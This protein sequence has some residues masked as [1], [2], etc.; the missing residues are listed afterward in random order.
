MTKLNKVY[1]LL[2]SN[3]EPRLHYLNEAMN[4]LSQELGD[5]IDSSL[6]YESDALG[7][8]SNQK[9]LNQV[10]AIN[11][12][13][14]AQKAL[15]TCLGIE[16][17]L[18]RIR[19]SNTVNIMSS[20]TIDIDILY[21]NDDIINTNNLIVPHPRLHER[22][23]TLLPLC[24]IAPAFIHPGIKKDNAKLLAICNDN[25]DVIILN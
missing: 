22:R 6:I 14:V 8:E 3:I 7:F 9:F 17:N 5:F 15:D 20:R 16:K 11:T 4:Q 18:G 25:S 13:L 19:E 21:Y 12:S 23:F 10:I 1:I 24:D 2:G